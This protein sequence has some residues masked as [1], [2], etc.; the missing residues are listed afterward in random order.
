MLRLPCLLLS[1][2]MVW[3]PLAHSEV[4]RMS[5]AIPPASTSSTQFSSPDKPVVVL[6]PQVRRIPRFDSAFDV[7]LTQPRYELRLFDQTELAHLY[8]IQAEPLA[9]HYLTHGDL[10]RTP[11][12][13]EVKQQI[14][15]IYRRLDTFSTGTA[16]RTAFLPIATARMTHNQPGWLTLENINQEVRAGD[17]LLMS[18]VGDELDALPN[19]ASALPLSQV[20]GFPAGSTY[21]SVG[22]WLV[23][24]KGHYEGVR[25]GAL[26]R[27]TKNAQ[28]VR[29]LGRLQVTSVYPHMSLAQ[30][31][32]SWQPVKASFWAWPMTSLT[33]E[34][35]E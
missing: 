10:I 5:S 26:Y 18:D 35:M 24:D 19:G 17:V 33:R 20:L 29:T 31:I 13:D 1:L 15:G 7:R 22:D 3:I 8:T 27:V 14:W 34:A 9:R 4:H 28:D 23:L 6:R 21:G 16:T 25:R 12:L 30:I 32:E 2:V 11:F